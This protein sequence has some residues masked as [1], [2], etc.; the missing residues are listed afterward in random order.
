M[1]APDGVVLSNTDKKK[2]YWYVERNLAKIECE[3]P[4][5][6]RLNF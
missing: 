4:L 3:E 5:I 6:I 2:A 1:L